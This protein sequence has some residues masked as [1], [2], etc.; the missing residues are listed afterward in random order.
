MDDDRAALATYI[1][2]VVL[3]IGGGMMIWSA[4]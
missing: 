3:A 1:F 4:L 2:A